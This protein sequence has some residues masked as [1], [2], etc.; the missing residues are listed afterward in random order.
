MQTIY[1]NSP[2]SPKKDVLAKTIAETI[3]LTL[4]Q[5]KGLPLTPPKVAQF[6]LEV[7]D[8][9]VSERWEDGT[10]YI[11]T[12]VEGDSVF[13]I[14]ERNVQF[15]FG[16]E[17]VIIEL[18]TN[19]IQLIKAKDVS[20]GDEEIPNIYKLLKG[21]YNTFYRYIEQ[22]PKV[23]SISVEE[24]SGI[25]EIVFVSS[26]N[27][28]GVYATP[29]WENE[30]F[31]PVD[32]YDSSEVIELGKIPITKK[33][34]TDF[35]DFT[36]WYYSQI[37]AIYAFIEPQQATT[38]Q[39]KFKVG[40]KVK[41]PK[42]KS[43]G[44]SY[45]FSN[46]IRLAIENGQDYMFVT[47]D[48]NNTDDEDG[49]S[50]W[51]KADNDSGDYFSIS[52]DKIELYDEVSGQNTETPS[53]MYQVGSVFEV[54]SG[55]VYKITKITN[56]AI[57]Y[58]ALDGTKPQTLSKSVA[59]DWFKKGSWTVIQQ[60]EELPIKVGDYFRWD[61][62]KKEQYCVITK[63]EELNGGWG[64]PVVTYDK[65]TSSATI[66]SNTKLVISNILDSIKNGSIKIIDK[67]K[68]TTKKGERKSPT[69]SANDV[70]AG[71]KMKGNDGNMWV[72]KKTTAG[73]NQWKKVK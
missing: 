34:F 47:L 64:E 17:G 6:V 56:Y 63:I 70:K 12:K 10:Y 62:Q 73:Y 44:Q 13:T 41:L 72:S 40:D 18:N 39:P 7:G 33:S 1:E 45:K 15:V 69:I 43:V 60:Q 52:K 29:F 23:K 25:F 20:N 57:E 68:P 26:A 31:I 54:P 36:E 55:D 28:T 53:T 27:D 32:S 2:E 37:D 14:D 5:I 65:R 11:I 3:R 22:H 30:F 50:L 16:K 66:S 46:G 61:F 51:W 35:A 38:T 71:T 19:I 21:N 67:P 58:E 59:D 9:L 4:Q 49:I 24:M 8:R 48:D 42:T